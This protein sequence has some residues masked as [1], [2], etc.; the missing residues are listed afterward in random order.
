[1][2]GAF[3]HTVRALVAPPSTAV[4]TDR[5]LLARFV[6]G[7]DEAAFTALVKRHGPMV[8]GLCRRILRC[9]SDMEDAFQATFLI[10]VQ[11]ANSIG[12]PDLL[13]N[14]LYGVAYRTALKA[15]ASAK[16]RQVRERAAADMKSGSNC[17]DDVPTHDLKFVLDDEINRLPDK[18][19][20]P[21]VL[22]C[23][24]GR[25]NEDAARALGCPHGTVLSRLARARQRLR[26]RL[27][28]RGLAPA[29]L[30][31]VLLEKNLAPAALPLSFVAASAETVLRLAADSVVSSAPI[32]VLAKGVVKT[33]LMTKVKKTRGTR[34]C[35]GRCCIGRWRA[36]LQ[37]QRAMD[38]K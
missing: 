20:A 6:T 35:A 21:F 34:G 27:T 29:G 3:L 7:G 24:E 2:A 36:P 30:A 33:M 13:G 4:L 28:R 19:R 25:T 17:S 8:L 14:W 5:E 1:M 11:K 15:R 12:R 26:T 9:H 38:R 32:V 10:L 22:C 16:V 18:Y 37:N 31:A 23:L